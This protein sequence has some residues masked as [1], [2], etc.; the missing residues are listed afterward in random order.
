M[1]GL[2]FNQE[3]SAGGR[4]AEVFVHAVILFQLRSSVR[5]QDNTHNQSPTIAKGRKLTE[6]ES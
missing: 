1:P 2:T 3:P 5:Q 4:Q 6:Q